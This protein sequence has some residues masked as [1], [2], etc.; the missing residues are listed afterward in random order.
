MKTSATIGFELHLRK[1]RMLKVSVGTRAIRD[2]I[3]SE[4]NKIKLLD[5]PWKLVYINKDSH[6]VYLKENQRLRNK[7]RDIKKQQGFEHNTGRVKITKGLLQ[8]DGIT[9][10]HNLFQI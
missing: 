2:K 3:C 1:K 7:M 6:P 10:D 8:V 9:V 5:A 4:S